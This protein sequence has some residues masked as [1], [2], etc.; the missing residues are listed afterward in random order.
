MGVKLEDEEMGPMKMSFFPMV[1]GAYG[2]AG[3][4]V[5]S[6]GYKP[7]RTGTVVYFSVADID[8]T[9]AKVKECGGKTVLPK[10]GIGKYGFIAHFEDSE[11]NRVALHSEK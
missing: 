6:E 9:L 4:L 2:A 7:S 1:E 10:M 8:K 5:K 3:G 11:G